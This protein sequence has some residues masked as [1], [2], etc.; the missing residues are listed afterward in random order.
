MLFFCLMDTITQLTLGAAVG[1]ATLGKKLGNRAIL[2]GAVAGEIPDLDVLLSPFFNEVEMLTVHRGYSHSILFALCM[3]PLL[4]WLFKKWYKEWDV[5]FMRWTTMWFLGLFTHMLLDSFTTYGTQLFL[6]FSDHRV[7][8]SNIFVADFFYTV[9][10][11]VSV[12]ACL[13][14]K[15]ESKRRALINKFGLAVSSLY[16]LLSFVFK[17]M[18][19]QEFK[20]SLEVQQIEY[21]R[22]MTG[23]TAL[24]I[25]LWYAV[26]EDE[27]GYY[28]GHYSIFDK[29]ETVEFT[30]M[31][32]NEDKIEKYLDDPLTKTLIWF[33]SGYYAIKEYD[34]KPYF[35]VL[36]FDRADVESE[37]VNFFGGMQL[38]EDENGKLKFSEV[39]FEEEL[40]W[41][42]LSPRLDALWHR[43]KGI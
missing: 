15:R 19:V 29:R 2:W 1:E 38:S 16:L 6:P 41:E 20:S 42:K 31:E 26:V 7:E 21:Q 10:F 9:P 34:G 4:G 24:N 27:H 32:R 25:I 28:F 13:F 18:A 37:E 33:S 30:Y 43:M 17:G 12:I 36:K 3:A 22:F 8:F 5:S 23:P 40:K 11:L 39:W 14:Y 35:T